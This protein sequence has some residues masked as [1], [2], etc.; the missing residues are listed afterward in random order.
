[1]LTPIT[2]KR[3]EKDIKL[4]K[5]RRKNLTKLKEVIDLLLEE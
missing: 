5:K 3:F 1:M 2:T 4:M